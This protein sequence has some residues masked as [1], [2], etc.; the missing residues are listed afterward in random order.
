IIVRRGKVVAYSSVEGVPGEGEFYAMPIILP[1]TI[2]EARNINQI[3]R[4]G[5]QSV[6]I[7]FASCRAASAFE[8]ALN[9]ASNKNTAAICE[10]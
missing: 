4:M 1:P 9:E 10:G 2:P 8:K 7:T 3:R 5:D 6:H